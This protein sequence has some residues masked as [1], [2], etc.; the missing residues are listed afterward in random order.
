MQ[1]VWAK[2][3]LA[4]GLGL[5]ILLPLGC[6]RK[7]APVQSVPVKTTVPQVGLPESEPLPIDE[8]MPRPSQA[9]QARRHAAPVVQMPSAAP[10]PDPQLA[11]RQRLQDQRLYE[12]QEAASQKAQR[13]L[14]VEVQQSQKAQ[15]DMQAEPRIQDAP[16]PAETGAPPGFLGEPAPGQEAPR[17]RDSP[18]PPSQTQPVQPVSPTPPQM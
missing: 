16:G 14:D 6:K 3:L 13:E 12:R 18:P 5:A 15:D 4:T 1:S 7:A 11:A 2:G 9:P 8:S 17:I 10:Q